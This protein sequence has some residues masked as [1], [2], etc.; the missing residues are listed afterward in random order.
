LGAKD[1]IANRLKWATMMKKKL[2][3]DPCY[4]DSVIFSDECFLKPQRCGSVFVRG[5]RSHKFANRY[6]KQKK[7][8]ENK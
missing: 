7:K 5:P 6:I 8:G 4:F 3:K 1:G 2:A